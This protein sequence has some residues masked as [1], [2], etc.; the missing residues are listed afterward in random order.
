L[1]AEVADAD[2]RDPA[3]RTGAT[4]AA[5]AWV[6]S[7]ALDRA[8]EGELVLEAEGDVARAAECSV[9]RVAA[10]VA[11]PNVASVGGSGDARVIGRVTE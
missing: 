1:D 6:L 4:V 5:E 9:A 10:K 2:V 3:D 11:R 8:S 7:K